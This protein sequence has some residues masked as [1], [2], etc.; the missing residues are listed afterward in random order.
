MEHMYLHSRMQVTRP[1]NAEFSYCKIHVMYLGG[2]VNGTWFSEEAVIDALP[3]IYN[4]PIVGEYDVHKDNFLDHGQTLTINGD[5]MRT[6]TTTKA[7][8]VIPE[9]ARI[10]WE[11]VNDRGIWRDYL[12]VDKAIL[13]TR[14]FH[15]L[16]LLMSEK[17]GQSMEIMVDRGHHEQK[18]EGRMYV[19]EKFH[20]S[21]FCILG[22]A[23]NGY[24][25]VQPAFESASIGRYAAFHQT[26]HQEDQE[27][28][29]MLFRLKELIET[30]A[31]CDEGNE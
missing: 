12:V 3:S 17:F 24:P 18:P 1:L 25:R 8:G 26:D 9:S 21:G 4:C 16:D 7:L 23:K 30:D 14:R 31:S 13:W 19:I 15:E 20:F 27:F 28:Q 2:N 29:E 6:T 5:W 10:Y 11:K 22:V